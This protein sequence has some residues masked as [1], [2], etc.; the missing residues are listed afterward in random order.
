MKSN[1]SRKLGAVSVLRTNVPIAGRCSRATRTISSAMPRARGCKGPTS[2][3]N[4]FGASGAAALALAPCLAIEA[5]MA[6]LDDVPAA[7]GGAIGR[8]LM[9][10]AIAARD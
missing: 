3:G 2:K 10:A 9:D 7:L 6:N 8:L 4:G 1:T 5:E